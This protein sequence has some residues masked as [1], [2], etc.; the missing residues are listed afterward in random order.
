MGQRQLI[1]REGRPEKSER[2]TSNSGSNILHYGTYLG[3]SVGLY[4]TGEPAGFI[5]SIVGAMI[6]LLLY[7]LV[8]KRRT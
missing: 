6:P 2:P 4:R 5:G 1:G 7:Q 8:I 3:Q